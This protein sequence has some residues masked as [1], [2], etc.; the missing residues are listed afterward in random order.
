MKPLRGEGTRYHSEVKVLE[1]CS[2]VPL[3]QEESRKIGHQGTCCSTALLG[4]G[5]RE[6]SAPLKF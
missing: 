4:R 1:S 6:V 5:R 3:L 2:L